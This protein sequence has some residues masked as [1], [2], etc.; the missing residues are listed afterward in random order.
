MLRSSVLKLRRQQPVRRPPQA[1][2]LGSQPLAGQKWI[3]HPVILLFFQN[4]PKKAPAT[5]VCCITVR[6]CGRRSICCLTLGEQGSK[7]A[8]CL[9][10]SR[11]RRTRRWDGCCFDNGLILN[12]KLT[13]HTPPCVLRASCLVSSSAAPQ[14]QKQ[15]PTSPKLPYK[16]EMVV[17]CLA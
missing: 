11:H 3:Q 8:A 9:A 15:V 13:V 4:V 1:P 2:A 6:V 12:G 14:K 5:T 17:V 10:V 16:S 7:N